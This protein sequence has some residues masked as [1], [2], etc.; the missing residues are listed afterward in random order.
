MF[1]SLSRVI[2][3]LAFL[4]PGA[5]P[6]F[7]QTLPFGNLGAVAEPFQWSAT[8]E[9]A[10]GVSAGQAAKIIVTARIQPDH[11]IYKHMTSFEPEFQPGLDFG[12]PLFPKAESIEDPFTGKP[13]EIYRG[14]QRF[15]IPFAI[16]SQAEASTR[17]LSLTV[18]YQGCSSKVCFLPR[19]ET[20]LIPLR[21]ESSLSSPV[22][23]TE[24]IAAVSPQDGDAEGAF[25]EVLARGTFW[26]FLFVF[27]GGILTSFTPCVYPLIPITIS[28][29]GARE[30]T[31]RLK[32]FFLSSFYVLGIATMYSILGVIA[33][34]TGA[35]FGQYLASGWLL[36]GVAAVF[37]ILGA[38]M[39]G[40]FEIRLPAGVQQRLS[41]AG[42]KGVLGA[43]TM[44]LFG[45]LIA[46]PCTGPALGAVLAYVTTTRDVWLGF[47]LLFVFALGLGLLFLVLGTFSSLIGRLPKSGAWMDA[48][49]SVFAIL[50]FF[51]A[52][53]FLRGAVPLLERL[54]SYSPTLF[55]Q[56][57]VLTVGGLL[58]GAVH[59]RF[60]DP[61]P[62]VRWAKGLGLLLATFG[63]FIGVGSLTAQRGD[64]PQPSWIFSES[65]G[66]E[67]ARAQ[68]KPVLID[69]YADWCAACVEL[70]HR[71]Y[72]DS[73]VLERLEDFVSI[74]LDF[75]QDTAESRQ[76]A[77]K[78][79]IV[80]LPTIVIYDSEGTVR[81]E[82]RITGFIDADS[83]LKRL[84]D[85]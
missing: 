21:I 32:A 80:G 1:R 75:T 6:A 12:S 24:A 34:A 5:Q 38:S 55:A 47:W 42:G 26:A 48:V 16:S 70:D 74:K 76:L 66:L 41:R 44:G 2:L 49:K 67:A 53:Y 62:R 43:Y 50:L 58:L 18:G 60:A 11:F 29:F 79:A 17:E 51:F 72:S 30:A 10:L 65:E 14:E 84:K 37:V 64:L 68:G 71:T 56:A 82:K 19:T 25:A 45:G 73:R 7:A 3:L 8:V 20:L 83:F 35:V 33:A 81:P 22:E 31:S 61:S 77:E 13:K 69:F 39:L 54:W 9:P 40:L 85:L 78:Y 15:E 23:P 46:A 4:A 63:L 28:L 59:K 27:V 57:G 52:L 36:A